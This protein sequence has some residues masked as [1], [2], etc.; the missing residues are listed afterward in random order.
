MVRVNN[1]RLLTLTEAAAFLSTTVW[2]VRSLIWDGR[3][4]F[5]R[6]GRRF[7]VDVRDLDTLVENL[8]Q[9]EVS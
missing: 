7:L 5:V 6:L 4:P 1:K 9:R 8:K 2:S 3:L